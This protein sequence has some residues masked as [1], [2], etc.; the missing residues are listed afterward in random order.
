MLNSKGQR[1]ENFYYT[2]MTT[3]SE[4]DPVFHWE[5]EAVTLGWDWSVVPAIVGTVIKDSQNK[6][7]TT[8]LKKDYEGKSQGIYDR[9]KNGDSNQLEQNDSKTS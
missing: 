5:Y 8:H 7:V 1:N 6:C 9:D 2:F 3:A 4:L